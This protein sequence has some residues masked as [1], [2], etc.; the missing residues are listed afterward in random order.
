MVI[1]YVSLFSQISLTGMEGNRASLCDFSDVFP[2]RRI[3]RLAR[4]RRR[5]SAAR[6]VS[7][8]FASDSFQ[9]RVKI[10]GRRPLSD[11]IHRSTLTNARLGWVQEGVGPPPFSLSNRCAGVMLYTERL[12]RHRQRVMHLCSRSSR[13]VLYEHVQHYSSEL[14]VKRFN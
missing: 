4:K 1:N 12:L 14:T 6:D 8:D 2:T 11:R 13:D 9:A 3:R 10:E 5:Q 7:F